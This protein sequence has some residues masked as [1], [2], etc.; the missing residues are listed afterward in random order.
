MLAWG[1]ELGSTHHKQTG[2]QTTHTHATNT[3][4]IF[5]IDE[6]GDPVGLR[7]VGLSKDEQVTRTRTRQQN[8]PLTRT[9]SEQRQRRNDA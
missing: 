1:T 3:H 7:V 5:I 4:S 2:G 6:G 9:Q 8:K